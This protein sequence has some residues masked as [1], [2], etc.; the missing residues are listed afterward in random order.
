MIME[1]KILASTGLLF[2]TV[3]LLLFLMPFFLYSKNKQDIEREGILKVTGEIFFL[4]VVMVIVASMF[5]V[6]INV[7]ITKPEF[8]PETGLQYFYGFLFGGGGSTIWDYWLN[9]SLAGNF[10]SNMG[11]D[12][13]HSFIVLMKYYSVMIYLICVSIPLAVLWHTVGAMTVTTQE[14]GWMG[15]QEILKKV[16][17]GAFAFFGS[18]FI[19]IAHCELSSLFVKIAGNHD[20][21]FFKLINAA[22][23]NILFG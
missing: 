16:R 2:G 6:A 5:A 10:G 9:K 18:T 11:E 13:M 7:G 22:W 4:H 23:Y 8:R 12:V 21:D 15:Y 14:M 1:D 19:V 20:F 17:T 3:S